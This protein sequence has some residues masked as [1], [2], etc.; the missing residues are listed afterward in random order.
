MFALERVESDGGARDGEFGLR[1]LLFG[2]AEGG[3]IPEHALEGSLGGGLV[4]IEEG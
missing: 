3:E 1:F 2:A 4:A